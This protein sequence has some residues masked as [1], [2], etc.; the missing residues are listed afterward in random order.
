MEAAMKVRDIMT[1]DV[2]SCEKETDIGTAARF[3]LNRRCGTLPVVDRHGGLAGIITDRDIAMAAATRQR[4]ASHI[5]VHEAMTGAVRR[6]FA[7]DEVGAAL[8]QME[9]ARVRRLPVVDESGH[10]AGIVSID[11]IV[12]RALDRPGGI[13]SAAFVNAQT[14]ISAQPSVEPEVDMSDTYVSG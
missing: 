11:D 5:A 8:K 10:L 3:M 2:A 14:R 4:N 6:C 7:D 1:R 13:S 9:E 12:L